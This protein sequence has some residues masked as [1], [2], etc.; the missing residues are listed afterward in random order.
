MGMPLP[1]SFDRQQD[2]LVWLHDFF[3]CPF[4]S[5]GKFSQDCK[6]GHCLVQPNKTYR[7][8]DVKAYAERIKHDRRTATVAETR[9]A[10]REEWEIRKLKADVERKE[11]ENRKEDDRWVLKDDAWEGLAAL[12]GAMNSACRH[13]N[14]VLAPRLV[15][16]LAGS[17][18]RTCHHCGEKIVNEGV[19]RL[20][21]VVEMLDE[22]DREVFNSLL[23]TGK[24]EGVFE[25]A[26][27]EE[28]GTVL[29]YPTEEEAR[30]AS[31]ARV[32]PV[33]VPE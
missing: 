2:A 16:L 9:A 8:K 17:G 11:M 13:Q 31:R 27:A 3:G 4:P 26:E 21:E 28:E 12:F 15:H 23:A 25:E 5:A 22:S 10:E 30:A 33:G 18:D 6:N 14:H 24:V 29:L 20:A 19:A 7:G 32:E 1:E